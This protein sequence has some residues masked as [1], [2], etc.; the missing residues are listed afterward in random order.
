MIPGVP[1]LQ[2]L[3]VP[4]RSTVG[5]QLLLKMG[6]REGEGVGPKVMKYPPK[7]Q[8]KKGECNHIVGMDTQALCHIVGMN[9]INLIPRLLLTKILGMRLNLYVST[10][11]S[12]TGM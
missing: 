12:T 10:Y 7:T 11:S 6:W 3:I 9:G 1:P 2:N 5:A 8:E 4:S